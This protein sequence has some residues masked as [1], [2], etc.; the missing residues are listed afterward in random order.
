VK[1]ESTPFEDIHDL[2]NRLL[3]RNRYGK[4]GEE[5]MKFSH[6]LILLL[7]I[8]LPQKGERRLLLLGG[9]H[10]SLSQ[11]MMILQR[12]LIVIFPYMHKIYFDQSNPLYYSFLP[13]LSFLKQSFTGFIILFSHTHVKYFDHIHPGEFWCSR[14]VDRRIHVNTPMIG[15]DTSDKLNP[16]LGVSLKYRLKQTQFPK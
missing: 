7:S 12:A 1:Y 3:S 13:L 8:V 5:I 14:I 11:H 4:H 9:Y 10:L 15:G 6:H 2:R 16:N